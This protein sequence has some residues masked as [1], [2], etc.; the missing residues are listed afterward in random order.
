MK[1]MGLRHGPDRSR[2]R[3][4]GHRGCATAELV[5]SPPTPRCDCVNAVDKG[6]SG[7]FGV[8]AVDKGLT[9]LPEGGSDGWADGSVLEIKGKQKWTV[10]RSCGD[11]VLARK[12]RRAGGRD[13]GES[14]GSRPL[15]VNG[16]KDSRRGTL[17]QLVR[18]TVEVQVFK[19]LISQKAVAR[20]CFPS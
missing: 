10:G 5:L 11:G 8:K 18:G 7:R 2:R 20:A 9:A 14:V 19:I 4:A 15:G 6:V 13:I 16:V 17:G 3:H 12:V 1:K